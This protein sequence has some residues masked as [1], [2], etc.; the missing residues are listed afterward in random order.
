MV[1]SKDEKQ[2]IQLHFNYLSEGNKNMPF[3]GFVTYDDFSRFRIDRP[4]VRLSWMNDTIIDWFMTYLQTKATDEN[5][6]S[7][8]MKVFDFL[9]LNDSIESTFLRS[10]NVSELRNIYIPINVANSH[11]LLAIIDIRSKKVT[12]YDSASS[13]N[14]YEQEFNKLTKWLSRQ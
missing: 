7:L 5:I 13:A 1:L 11:W 4:E 9:S 3:K 10:V 2:L 8:F 12:F 6:K 14:T